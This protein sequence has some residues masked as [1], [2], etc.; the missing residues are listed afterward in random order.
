MIYASEDVSTIKLPEPTG[1][2]GIGTISFHLDS[3]RMEE[4]SAEPDDYRQIQIQIQVQVRYPAK[5]CS[6]GKRSAYLDEPTIDYIIELLPTIESM[7]YLPGDIVADLSPENLFQDFPLLYSDSL[8]MVAV[9]AKFKVPP[10]RE[11]QPFPLLIFSPGHGIVYSYYQTLIEEVVSHGYVVAAV[12][13]PYISGIT[14]YRD[15]S[16]VEVY[17]PEID[18]ESE[19]EYDRLHHQF[20]EKMHKLIVDD[21]KLLLHKL[22]GWNKGPLKHLINTK[23]VGFWGH[24]IGGAAAVET[25]LQER[26]CL[27]AV[28]IDGEI[29]G[30]QYPIDKPVFLI[31]SEEV[32]LSPD[33]EEVYKE[34]LHKMWQNIDHDGYLMDFTGAMHQSW[35]DF[36]V[37][38][39]G[40]LT[41]EE[42]KPY[43]NYIKFLKGD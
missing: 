9:N 30:R 42:S 43:E 25:C 28:N 26:R 6:I 20:S 38:F 40:I 1:N 7:K 35:Y 17:L 23:K 18:S 33:D 36:G 24:S 27:G 5:K 32:S 37:I 39:D 12:N 2:Y 19:E 41:S 21:C 13:H 16:A 31:T 10:A 3:H 11:S 4:M 15:G 22:E 8:K 29:F 14:T 34:T